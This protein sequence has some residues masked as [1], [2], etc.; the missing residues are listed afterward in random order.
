MPKTK[1]PKRMFALIEM[2]VATSTA[3]DVAQW[4]RNELGDPGLRLL[5]VHVNVARPMP[6]MEPIGTSGSDG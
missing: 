2:E 3:Q 1:K 4:L 5:Q 6:P